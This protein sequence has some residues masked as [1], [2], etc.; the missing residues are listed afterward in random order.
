MRDESTLG[1]AYKR[2]CKR[3]SH[4]WAYWNPD[5][6]DLSNKYKVEIRLNVPDG[7]EVEVKSIEGWTIA[8]RK[9]GMLFLR[10]VQRIH[11]QGVKDLF[12]DALIIA[13]E[14]GWQFHSWKHEPH[15]PDWPS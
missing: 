2:V 10:R 5:E 13:N 14:N 8:H 7:D 3:S 15:L 12:L 6:I 4:F 9:S 11:K 1:Q